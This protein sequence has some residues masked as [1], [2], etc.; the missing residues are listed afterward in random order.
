MC[1]RDYN[2]RVRCA[3]TVIAWVADRWPGLKSAI[4]YGIAVALAE[5]WKP[6]TVRKIG[7]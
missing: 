5:G 6:P 7:D 4:C 3:Y 1:W 2:W